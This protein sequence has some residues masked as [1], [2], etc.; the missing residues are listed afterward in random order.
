MSR[1]LQSLGSVVTA[2]LAL[3][4]AACER[5]VVADPNAVP[6]PGDNVGGNV[7]VDVPPVIDPPPLIEPLDPNAC[8]LPGGQTVNC[9]EQLGTPEAYCANVYPETGG[10]NF[11][12]VSGCGQCNAAY[13]QAPPGADCTP[14]GLFPDPI[15][16]TPPPPGFFDLGE[17][18]CKTCH[19]PSN[20]DG[21]NSIENPHAW[22][23]L[24]CVECHG[25]DG[26]ATNQTF[27]H[28]CP[29]PA[30]GNRQQ[31]VLDTRAFFLSFTTAG[32]QLLPDYYCA[33]QGGEQRLT[34]ALEW[35]AFKNP[36]DLRSGRAGHGCA[37]CHNDVNDYVSRS[38]MGT[39]TGLNGGTR[40]G[41]GALNK[42]ADR[43]GNAVQTDWNTQAEYGATAVTNPSYDANNRIVGEVPSLYAPPVYTGGDFRYDQT[44]TADA[45]N[46]SLN[47]NNLQADNYPNGVNNAVAEQ[48]FQEV[49]NQACTGCHLQNAYNNFR[50]GDYRS[51]G[52]A[53]CH[54]QRGV[55]GRSESSDPNVRKYE[56]VDP[57]FL[58]PGE[59]SHPKD[60]RIRNVAK[61][62][63][64]QAGLFL[65]MQGIADSNCIVCHEGSNRMVAQ[66][67]GYRLDQNQ[68]MTNGNFYP[69]DNEVLVTYRSQ[70]FGE[71]QF[72]NNRA[73]TQWIST[74]IWQTDVVDVIGVGG[75]DE[76]P[77]DLHHDAGMGCID[78][79]G[80]GATHGRGQIYSRMKVATHQNDVLCETC[81]G[82][83]DAYAQNDGTYVL[84][85]AGEPLKNIRVNGNPAAGEI[86]LISKL[87]GGLHYIPQTRDTV[88]A[89]L[90]GVG[91][92][93]YPG[94][95][96]KANQPIFNYTAS[97]AMGRY[98]SAQNLTDGFGPEQPDSNGQIQM[99]E[100]FS[101]SDGEAG[102]GSNKG[103]ECYTCHSAWQNNCIGCHLDAFYDND[104]NNYFYS[105]VTGERIYFN[106]NA[107]FVYQNPINFMMGINDR[108][109]VSPY[110]GL[111]RFFSYTDIN[112]NTSDR[113]SYGDR[114]GLGND[115][116]LKNPNR[117]ALPALQN[118]P[119]MPHST[120]NRYSTTEIGMRGCLDCHMGNADVL[121][122][123]DQ[124]ND[125]YDLTD[126]Y[127]NEYLASALVRI[128]ESRGLGS[129]L[130]LF[131]ADGEAVVDTNN[132]AVYDL[133]RLVEANGATNTSSNHPL[134]DPFG[135]NSNPMYVQFNDTNN[136][137]VA[138]PFTG[139]L[140]NKLQVLD[141]FGLTNVYYYNAAVGV[142]PNDNGY[143][144]YFLN[145]YNY[146]NQ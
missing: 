66:Y 48:L 118:Q 20:Y 75:Q 130:W 72:F 56:P 37:Q 70:L 7:P 94:G 136:A 25:G 52:C 93:T 1:T 29:P 101:H 36:G 79:H 129:N 18:T 104:P 125:A 73:L 34:T 49:L 121:I 140:L 43:R 88:N 11:A 85:Q 27:A 24:D 123:K 90:G 13:Y 100:N 5:P 111:H 78:C 83:I 137:R 68:D 54:F 115:P 76:T 80:T 14:G 116:A 4:L 107:D 23:T 110:Q 106:F 135:Q 71:N 35:L 63:G 122:M 6:P 84:D 33:T 91:G 46:N 138:R 30:V 142:D 89:S 99:R 144:T 132:A 127:A 74:E 42:F 86:W 117:N 15:D 19:A 81:H 97:Y 60:H 40:H 126:V 16:N 69:S 113:V 22:V 119:F 39:A 41:I 45:V 58:T 92:K 139:Q 120:R 62:P 32:I 28:V 112:N 105:Q 134:L 67:Q 103:L 17:S 77:A 96:P 21:V 65:V 128:P 57:N 31:Q 2:V 59:K 102:V 47:L 95:T 38:V 8:P 61:L 143:Y 53:A 64:Q 145:N 9:S 114:N 3:S 108:G 10:T 87:N 146:V 109:K 133:D 131:D 44:Y 98:Q 82:T 12:L 26:A 55:S 50:A 124:A 141:N 51:T